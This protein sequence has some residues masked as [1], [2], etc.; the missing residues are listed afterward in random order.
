[1]LNVLN[2]KSKPIHLSFG[3]AYSLSMVWLEFMI[4]HVIYNPAYTYKFQLK[5]T[6]VKVSKS[7]KQIVV[8][9]ILPK[10]EQKNIVLF[11]QRVYSAVGQKKCNTI[12]LSNSS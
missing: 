11:C 8:S 7:Q 5:I 12:L 2:L 9:S 6:F 4:G 3:V 1:M 10:N